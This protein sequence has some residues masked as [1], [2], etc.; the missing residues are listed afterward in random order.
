MSLKVLDF[1]KPIYLFFIHEDAY[2]IARV[3][4]GMK[5]DKF[6]ILNECISIITFNY[7]YIYEYSKNNKIIPYVTTLIYSLMYE[8]E[9]INSNSTIDYKQLIKRKNISIEKLTNKYNVNIDEY[10]KYTMCKI[11]GG[12]ELVLLKHDVKEI[13]GMKNINDLILYKFS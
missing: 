2:Y 4:I 11:K 3:N 10:N 1:T 8:E 12:E 7:A 6:Y 13:N 9:T 5:E